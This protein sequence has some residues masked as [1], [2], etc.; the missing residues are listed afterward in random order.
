MESRKHTWFHLPNDTKI[1]GG[2][3]KVGFLFLT[4]DTPTFSLSPEQLLPTH[5]GAL[6]IQTGSSRWQGESYISQNPLKTEVGTGL[7]SKWHC[8][9]ISSAQLGIAGAFN[10]SNSSVWLW[11]AFSSAFVSSPGTISCRSRIH[12]SQPFSKEKQVLVLPKPPAKCEW[13]DCASQLTVLPGLDR[14]ER[15]V[16]GT[17]SRA[18]SSISTKPI[19]HNGSWK[20]GQ[21]SDQNK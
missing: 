10:T 17:I 2:L 11:Q 3:E 9:L 1:Q 4:R 7:P 19:K 21:L 16:R 5:P 8:I 13:C 14:I 15:T 18:S 12:C 20:K 6:N